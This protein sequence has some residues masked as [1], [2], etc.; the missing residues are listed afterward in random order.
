MRR[1]PMSSKSIAGSCAAH[2]F[3]LIVTIGAVA[4][5]C[6]K[7][8]E[9]QSALELQRA[10]WNRRVAALQGRV[11][12]LEARLHALPPAPAGANT[13]A[14]AQRQRLQASVIGARQTL[15]DIQSHAA[16]GA[17]DVESALRR[18]HVEAEETLGGL[19]TRMNEF[20]Q[21]QEQALAVNEDAITRIGENV[22]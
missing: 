4:G 10:D 22:R 14:L 9:V 17:R 19:A 21:Q 13:A 6:D 2:W 8:G 15:I 18:D 12:N 1:P 7:S 16:D 20:L 3:A 5:A 11:G